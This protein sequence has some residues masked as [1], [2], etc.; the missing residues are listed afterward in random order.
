MSGWAQLLLLL[1]ALLWVAGIVQILRNG[2]PQPLAVA[3]TPDPVVE[4]VPTPVP[5]PEPIAQPWS[6]TEPEPPA[7]KAEPEPVEDKA[8][9]DEAPAQPEAE[10]TAELGANL[11][12]A[13]AEPQAPEASALAPEPERVADP[14]PADETPETAWA[15]AG[16]AWLEALGA[17]PDQQASVWDSVPEMADRYPDLAAP[18]ARLAGLLDAAFLGA[19]ALLRE[20]AAPDAT[21]GLVQAVFGPGADVIWPQPGAPVGDHEALGDGPVVI[22]CLRPGFRYAA[23]EGEQVLPAMVQ[24]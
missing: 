5:K 17:S 16:H 24:T 13:A 2:E 7:R 23:D 20:A 19:P 11:S 4:R 9:P 3:N 21:Q 12:E 18:A 14:A 1:S 15:A 8:A 10:A 6:T 22:A